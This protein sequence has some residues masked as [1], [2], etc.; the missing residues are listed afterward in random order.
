MSRGPT[1][2]EFLSKFLEAYHEAWDGLSPQMREQV[3]THFHDWNLFMLWRSGKRPE[4]LEKSVL[5]GTAERL[6][7]EYYEAEPLRFDGAFYDKAQAG[8][9]RFPF[10][11]LVAFEHENDHRG[12]DQEIVK[13]LSVRCPLKVGI[14]YTLLDDAGANTPEKR[15]NAIE[16]IRRM[17]ISDFNEI[18]AVVKEDASSEYLFLV[19][20]EER[21]RS[22]EWYAMTFSSGQDPETVQFVPTQRSQFAG[23]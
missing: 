14:T 19:G 16:A 15:K 18:S 20:A 2:K 23:H 8:K 7:L 11:I 3:W 9:H 17:V 6:D 12:F 22:L 13:L 21:P 1:A 4:G 5:A 10:P